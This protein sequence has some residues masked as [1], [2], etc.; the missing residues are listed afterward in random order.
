[1]HRRP[2][3]IMHSR[4]CLILHLHICLF[5]YSSAGGLVLIQPS[6]LRSDDNLTFAWVR[7]AH[8]AHRL[9]QTPAQ[10]L[11]GLLVFLPSRLFFVDCPAAH[12]NVIDSSLAVG[13]TRICG[14]PV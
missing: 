13:R 14:G 2:F 4:V 12:N 8:A 9:C 10:V 11:T 5:I 6:P 1:M 3:T 7:R